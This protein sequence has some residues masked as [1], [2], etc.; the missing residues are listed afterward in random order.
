MLKKSSGGQNR[1]VVTGGRVVTFLVVCLASKQCKYFESQWGRDGLACV[2]LFG[3][4]L[5]CLTGNYRSENMRTK[6]QSL[7]NI[8]GLLVA[9]NLAA[10][11][12]SETPS[13]EGGGQ[14]QGIIGGTVPVEKSI[15]RTATVAIGS[16]DK[17]TG[18]FSSFCTGIVVSRD[19]VLTAAHCMETDV[20]VSQKGSQS[21]SLY[22]G[23][24]YA[25]YDKSLER[26]SRKWE[27]NSKYAPIHEPEFD[28][29]VSA[30][31]DVA[32][33]KV[34]GGVPLS[35]TPAKIG[36][37]LNLKKGE[38]ITAA[39]WGLV[40][41]KHNKPGFSVGAT[42]EEVSAP[43][44]QADDADA[45]R[46]SDRLYETHISFIAYWKTHMVFQQSEKNGVCR[47]DSGGPAY[48]KSKKYGYVLIGTVRGAHAFS[49]CDGL[50]E[51]TNLTKNIDFIKKAAAKLSGAPIQIVSLK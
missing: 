13:I 19:L 43:V 32:L 51:Y 7:G 8:L 44:E 15:A 29:V 22:F 2:L 31:G 21:V 42:E 5:G 18:R 36:I 45:D 30:L 14:L 40:H 49:Y 37:D 35:S 25:N 16:I 27:I 50:V 46:V 28:M 41:E 1:W 26:V 12:G 10:C 34:E 24:A 4:C 47:G 3:F 17:T 11:A 6:M 20:I 48:Y 23:N 33:L 9:L 39:G 38:Q